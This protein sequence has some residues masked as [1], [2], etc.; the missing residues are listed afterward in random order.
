MAN[1]TF[2]I[3]D[4]PAQHLLTARTVSSLDTLGADLGRLYGQ[5]FGVVGE[6]AG[7]PVCIYPAPDDWDPSRFVALAGVPFDGA[8][9]YGFDETDLPG[10]RA[11]VA[12][13]TGGYSGLADA[14]RAAFAHLEQEKLEVASAPYE[15]YRDRE[16]DIVIPLK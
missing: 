5:L 12:T 13:Y 8:V 1:L 4:V 6:R 16:T 14:W 9:P 3:D 15:R 7:P 10:G 11:L 2:H